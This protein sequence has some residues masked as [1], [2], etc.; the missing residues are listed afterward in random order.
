MKYVIIANAHRVIT[1]SILLFVKIVKQQKQTF[2]KRKNLCGRNICYFKDGFLENDLDLQ[3]LT[4]TNFCLM[5]R[6]KN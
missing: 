1:W 3:E 5:V 6:N 4:K 2:V